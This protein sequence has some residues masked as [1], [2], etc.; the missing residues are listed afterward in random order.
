MLIYDYFYTNV[1]INDL[2]IMVDLFIKMTTTWEVF[3]FLFYLLLETIE[4][5]YRIF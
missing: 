4:I 3:K 5:I 1:D 2:I